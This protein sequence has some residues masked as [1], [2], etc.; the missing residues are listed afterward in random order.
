MPV[1]AGPGSVWAI[2]TPS[3]KIQL[4]TGFEVSGTHFLRDIPVAGFYP[5]DATPTQA[6]AAFVVLPPD[7]KVDVRGAVDWEGLS[8]EKEVRFDLTIEERG[9]RLTTIS[10]PSS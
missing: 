3:S 1:E 2:T 9:F 10:T 7:L 8:G 6:D 5:P 4:H